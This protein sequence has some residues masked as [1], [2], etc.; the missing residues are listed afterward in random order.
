MER[1]TGVEPVPSAWQADVPPP[2]PW[3]HLLNFIEIY[4]ALP[5]GLEPLSKRLGGVCFS[6]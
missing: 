5:K 2:T 6:N 4:L 3:T 1:P